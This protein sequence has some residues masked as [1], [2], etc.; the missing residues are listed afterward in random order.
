MFMT[1]TIMNGHKAVFLDRDGVINKEVNY[2][3][4]IED[5]VFI[6]GVIEA[7]QQFVVAGYKIIVITN[8]AG[9]ARGFYTEND[10]KR[11]NSWMVSE[12]AKHNVPITAVYYCPHH[13]KEGKA[14]YNIQCNCRKP[15][16]GMI[17]QAQ[18]EHNIDVKNS[19][20]FGDK[21]SDIGA[22]KAAGVG[23]NILLESGHKLSSNDKQQAD[24][25]F[26]SLCFYF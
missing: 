16:P 1:D 14:P 23:T 7:C 11:L 13:A 6:D 19:L 25:V 5:F 24:A 21:V 12:F 22:G 20:L 2:L 18:Q 26:A 4:K 8:Q 15:A 9:I 17:L 3:H 10:F